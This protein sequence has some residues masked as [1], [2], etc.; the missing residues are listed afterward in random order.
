M[1]LTRPKYNVRM[2][3]NFRGPRRTSPIAASPRSIE[4]GSF[5]WIGQALY[6]DLKGEYNFSSRL[7]VF[8]SVRNLADAMEDV[9]RRG[10]NTPEQAKIFSRY[11]YAQ[12]W[13]VGVK[14]T[15]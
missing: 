6:V 2:N 14:G 3:W 8:A 10:P 5:N 12:L 1:S 15:F 13:T 9:E 4:A 7:G 11:D